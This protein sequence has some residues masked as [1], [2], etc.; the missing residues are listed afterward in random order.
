MFK[1]VRQE[2]ALTFVKFQGTAAAASP[3]LSRV[4][5]RVVKMEAPGERMAMKVDWKTLL[6]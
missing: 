5:R 6:P 4:Q 3:E 1:R 2:T